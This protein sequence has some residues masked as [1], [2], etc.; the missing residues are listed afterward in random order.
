[1]RRAD[2]LSQFKMIP[3]DQHFARPGIESFVRSIRPEGFMSHVQLNPIR[4]GSA[5]LTPGIERMR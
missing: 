3:F 1:M 4:D 5:R 2:T